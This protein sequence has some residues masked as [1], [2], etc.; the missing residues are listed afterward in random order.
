MATFLV[1]SLTLLVFFVTEIFKYSST[2][3][4]PLVEE[5]KL[6]KTII[7]YDNERPTPSAAAGSIVY[8]PS[9][10]NCVFPRSIIPQPY[11]TRTHITG[12][13]ISYVMQYC[14]VKRM[15]NDNQ[16]IEYK[17]CYLSHEISHSRRQIRFI[18]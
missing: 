12:G 5:Q 6:D 15:H 18:C 3:L 2:V 13:F 8:G 16:G 17:L 14:G 11:N 1:E 7:H 4:T 10:V 9:T